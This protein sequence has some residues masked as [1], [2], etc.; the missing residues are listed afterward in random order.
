MSTGSSVW[1]FGQRGTITS[2][3]PN[4]GQFGT[5]VDIA[6]TLLASDGSTIVAV[7]LANIPAVLYNYSNTR[8]VAVASRS[9]S[10]VQG[11]VV[12]VSETGGRTT[13]T[14]GWN[15]QTE[16]QVI[17]VIPSSGMFG[18]TVIIYG[19]NLR[20]YG[21]RLLQVSLVGK[22]ATILD[23]TDTLVRVVANEQTPGTGDVVLTADS[24]AVVRRHNA[25]Q[26]ITAGNVTTVTPSQGQAGTVVEI[27]GVGLLAGGSRVVSVTLAGIPA[28][29]I[30][31]TNTVIRV[32]VNRGSGVQ[33]TGAIVIMAE[34]NAMITAPNAWTYLSEGQIRSVTPSQGQNGAVVTIAG[35]NLYGGG[36]SIR[37]VT[38]AGVDATIVTQSNTSIVVVANSLGFARLGDVVLL[39]DTGAL[40]SLRDG[41]QYAAPGAIGSVSPQA[42]QVGTVVSISGSSLLGGGSG[43]VRAVLDGVSTQAIL[44]SNN[45]LVVVAANAS[46]AASSSAGSVTLYSEAG[47]FV[48]GSGLWSHLAASSITVGGVSPA[49]G[50]FGTLVTINGTRL[51]GGGTR[52]A[53]AS[54]VGVSAV[55]VQGTSNTSAVVQAQAGSAG[56]G[57]V[58][59]TADTGARTTLEN[60]WEYVAVGQVATVQPSNGQYATVV[61]IRGSG[62]LGGGASV[63]SVTL[64]GVAATLVSGNATDIVVTAGNSST[65]QANVDVVVT[66][67]TGAVVRSVG[68]WS[69]LAEGQISGVTPSS[70]QVGTLVTISGQRLLGGGTSV[71]LVTLNGVGV[72]RIASQSN[73][74][75]VV[76]VNSSSV[77]GAGSVVLYSNTGAQV[78][79]TAPSGVFTYMASGVVSGISPTSGQIGTRVTI[80]GTS[81]RGWGTRVAQ[82]TLNGQAVQNITVETDTSVEVVVARGASAASRDVVLTSDSGAR[83]TGTGLWT[84]LAE[85]SISQVLPISGQTGTVLTIRGT[86]LFGGSSAL[87]SV[88]IGGVT[89]SQILN[90]TNTEVVV[91]LASHPAGLATLS[92]ISLS[93]SI[94]SNN[95]L[96]TVISAGTLDLVSPSQGQLGVF[97]NLYGV[98]LFGGGS[99]VTRVLF[100]S[101][102]A[103]LVSQTNATVRVRAGESTTLGVVDVTL[104]SDTGA[105][106]V[107]PSGF[108]YDIASN[109]TSVCV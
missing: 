57:H 70:G 106:I 88:L 84:Y 100:G 75:V 67:N 103:T 46:S 95:T 90:Q 31:F 32:V 58:I 37:Q 11:D 21:S 81:L 19:S 35:A 65:A 14:N 50:Q 55:V 38:L 107:R 25:W 76:E 49:S 87:S 29:I 10:A 99:N 64:G 18:T 73:T 92:L 48:T 4:L 54:L 15:Y 23:D 33:T 7:L 63:A 47:A 27:V 45:S 56:T 3:T 2:V 30:N 71:V 78:I 22:P 69:Y 16:G 93:G 8:V 74:Q 1:T 51:L 59:L 28:T 101:V 85:G 17:G 43:I 6:G 68:T 66:A 105:V 42:G 12:L 109:I 44:F 41:F 5:V 108:V 77:V 24:G 91:R 26:Y 61:T 97:V 82:V 79:G 98:N 52:I 72:A 53:N 96:F 39:S 60:G 40:V 62:L 20:G 9:S 89:V 104:I 36:N 34:T 83:V 94:V 13:L 80:S 102:P 86:D